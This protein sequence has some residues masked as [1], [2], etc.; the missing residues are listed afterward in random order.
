MY[1]IKYSF[2]NS[3]RFFLN[4]VNVVC[5]RCTTPNVHYPHIFFFDSRDKKTKISDLRGDDE[6]SPW[7]QER[8]GIIV[9]KYI[10]VSILKKNCTDCDGKIL[11][12]CRF[13][14]LLI[15]GSRSQYWIVVDRIDNEMKW[16]FSHEC[17][18]SVLTSFDFRYL[19]RAMGCLWGYHEGFC[20][21]LFHFLTEASER[22]LQGGLIH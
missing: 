17:A 2:I 14:I 21:C 19:S 4:T 13:A 18:E 15:Q 11:T 12:L 22:G 7:I 3:E 5:G 1:A 6:K 9:H 8:K 10:T 20:V 16:H